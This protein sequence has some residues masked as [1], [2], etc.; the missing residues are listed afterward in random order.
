M[1]NRS[2]WELDRFS[3]A[4]HR[5][6]AQKKTEQTEVTSAADATRDSEGEVKTGEPTDSNK[7]TRV[8][9]SGNQH[10]RVSPTPTSETNLSVTLSTSTAT[11]TNDNSKTSSPSTS[12]TNANTNTNTATGDPNQPN[13]Q[14]GNHLRALSMGAAVREFSGTDPSYTARE[15]IDLC[16]AT[17]NTCGIIAEEDK[18]AFLRSRLQPGSRASIMMQ[19]SAFVVT[20][21]E[22]DYSEFRINFLSAFGDSATL[23]MVKGVNAAVEVLHSK[24]GSLDPDMSSVEAFR[25]T[26][27]F[28]SILKDNGWIQGDMMTVQNVSTFLEFY[29]Y[30]IFLNGK[31]RRSTLSLMFEPKERLIHFVNRL[32]TKLRETNNLNSSAV[33]AALPSTGDENLEPSY[34]A[35][36]MSN[37]Q[38]YTCT[39][40]QREGH[41]A[42]R[43]FVRQKDQR[44]G[45]KKKTSVSGG[46]MSQNKDR[47]PHQNETG[48]MRKSVNTG[49]APASN[50][51]L[52]APRGVTGGPRYCSIHD[53]TNHST[54]ECYAVLK[55]RGE[56][57]RGSGGASSGEASRPPKNKG[58]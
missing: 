50:T 19:A 4:F 16:E 33:A 30:M 8:L 28:I 21:A 58:G 29:N 37:R 46:S 49:N 36:T 48:S 10:R 13:M 17:M 39:Y 52:P 40:C 25:V 11:M 32:K 23:S 41:T 45:H 5:L 14:L 51:N 9:R 43:C 26:G 6:C 20:Q 1:A 47:H 15:Y 55:M 34:A 2:N 12:N 54:D 42:G 18:I 24:G 56:M 57:G 7:S 31:C 35:V 27:D 22:K 38:V 44:K 53:S 3:E